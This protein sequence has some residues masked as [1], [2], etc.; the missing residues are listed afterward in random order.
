MRR[1]V[2]VNVLLAV[3][4]AGLALFF[5]FRPRPAAAPP[6][7]L[8][9]LDPE[10]V[11]RI[12]VERGAT[13]LVLEKRDGQWYLD[14]PYRARADAFRVRQLLDLLRAQPSRQFAATDLARFD[15]DHPATRV[16][17]D[18][19]PVAFGTVNELSNEQYVAAGDSVFLIPLRYAAGL[20]QE[21]KDVTGRAL[22]GPD[23]VP[24]SIAV[25]GVEMALQDGLWRLHPENPGL[26][27]DDLNRWGDDWQGAASLLTQRVTGAAKG[28]AITV[29]L[30]SG[31]TVP[32]TIVQREPELVLRRE[33]EGLQYHFAAAVGQR[34]MTPPTADSK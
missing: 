29:R 7:A 5:H 34:L 24:A 25:G 20:P 31:K 1:G 14:A 27:Q 18:D 13:A 17:F 15:L 26:S 2:L 4:V 23:E 33:D 30:K 32:L 8:S 21:A 22:F 3:L 19:R 6:L 16:V 28:D 9:S 11:T 10:R 12:R